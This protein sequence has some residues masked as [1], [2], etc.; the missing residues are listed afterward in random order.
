MPRQ[1]LYHTRTVLSTEPNTMEH[2]SGEIATEFAE[3]VWLSSSATDVLSVMVMGIGIP[4]P[5]RL[6]V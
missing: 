4:H 1:S 5:N 3:P 6:V 2:P